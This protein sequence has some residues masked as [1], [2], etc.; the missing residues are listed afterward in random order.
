[1]KLLS[2]VPLTDL[3]FNRINI[4]G[5]FGE[6]DVARNVQVINLT[7]RFSDPT[8]HQ[9]LVKLRYKQDRP[10]YRAYAYEMCV[11]SPFAPT[12]RAALIEADWV[13]AQRRLPKWKGPDDPSVLLAL[14]RR[15]AE[16][17]RW[18]D[19]EK[20]YKRSIELSPDSLAYE[21]LAETY[22][23]QNKLDR[24]KEALEESIKGEDTGLNH[25][26]VR[27][28]IAKE[29]MRRK[30]FKAAR[31]YAEAAAETGAGWA[32]LAA[33]D[34]YDGLGEWA[35]AEGMVRGAS[36][37]YSDGWFN[38]YLWCRRTG[39]G[40]VRA[41]EKFT[42]EWLAQSGD[43]L[44]PVDRTYAAVVYLLSDQKEKALAAADRA[45]TDRPVT[46]ALFTLASVQNALGKAADRDRTLRRISQDP[47][48][49]LAEALL[50]VAAGTAGPE[51]VEAALRWLP[52][53][54]RPDYCYHIG[55]FFALRGDKKNAAA[56]LERCA[57]A[58]EH[59]SVMFQSLAAAELRDVSEAGGEK[60]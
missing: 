11:I 9:T 15:Y 42:T 17:G 5:S 45:A 1:M 54:T 46:G 24:W 60:K 28:K 59:R 10:A 21:T 19:A 58:P 41:A 49:R 38:W 56:Y 13:E 52:D 33:A 18:D 36:E 43:R 26:V 39:H 32:M 35:L 47:E 16:V 37:R 2:R 34:C 22:R 53:Y 31:P 6:I 7:L 12:G 27:V 23:R 29:Y 40:D 30:D 57:L 48:K 44:G 20:S 50:G 8:F 4:V 14:G 25:A 51:A 55:H 3:D